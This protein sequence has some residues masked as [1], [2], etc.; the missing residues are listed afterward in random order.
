[1]GISV[2]SQNLKG[3]RQVF[4]RVW[5]FGNGLVAELDKADVKTVQGG[6]AHQ[7]DSVDSSLFHLFGLLD[8][9]A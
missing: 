3:P 4:P 5:L 7:P 1:M 2:R 9:Q 6:A 8:V